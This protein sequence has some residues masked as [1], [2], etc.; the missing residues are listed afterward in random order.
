ALVPLL[1]GDRLATPSELRK[2]APYAPGKERL[3]LDDVH[4]VVA[5]ASALALDA[6]VDAAFA[7]RTGEVEFH[8]AKAQTAGTGVGSILFAAQRQ[9]AALHKARLAVDQGTSVDTAVGGMYLNFRRAQ[10][11]QA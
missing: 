4:A 1:G 10:T 6:L 11:V 3:E 2:L 5:D 8:F 9:V 7:G